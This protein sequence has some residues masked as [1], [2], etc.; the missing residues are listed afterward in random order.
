MSELL[1]QLCKIIKK[2]NFFTDRFYFSFHK[3][4]CILNS[5]NEEHT[6]LLKIKIPNTYYTDMGEEGDCLL[7]LDDVLHKGQFSEVSD[8]N[9]TVLKSYSKFDDDIFCEDYRSLSSEA[10]YY[11]L[12]HIK[13]SNTPLLFRIGSIESTHNVKWFKESIIGVPV[14][15]YVKSGEKDYICVKYNYLGLDVRFIIPTSTETPN[16]YNQYLIEVD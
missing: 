15:L 1:L 7:D 11:F 16:I 6:S 4:F 14:K 13:N 5:M 3:Y 2:N 9:K 12:K 10:L 8:I